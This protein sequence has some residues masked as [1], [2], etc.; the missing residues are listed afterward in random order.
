MPAADTCVS[1]KCKS[2]QTFDLQARNEQTGGIIVVPEVE[3]ERE[4]ERERERERECDW[5]KGEYEAA[6]VAVAL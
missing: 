4:G 3:R 1:V 6:A 5:K 2:G